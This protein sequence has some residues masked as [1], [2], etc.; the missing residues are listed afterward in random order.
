MGGP[1]FF[2]FFF[3][4]DFFKFKEIGYVL[5]GDGNVYC[6]VT[7]RFSSM[8]RTTYIE[9][10]WVKLHVLPGTSASPTGCRT[11]LCLGVPPTLQVSPIN[12]VRYSPILINSVY[13]EVQ[14]LS[15]LTRNW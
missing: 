7:T 1:P 4:S 10:Y 15:F 14:G 2:F 3:L 5:R 6:C 8:N 11:L 9:Q 12:S 13:V